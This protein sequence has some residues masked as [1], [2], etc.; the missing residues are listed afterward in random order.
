MQHELERLAIEFKA[1]SDITSRPP[2]AAMTK[3]TPRSNK[4][5]FLSSCI[6]GDSFLPESLSLLI[7]LPPEIW[8]TVDVY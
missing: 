4:S 1:S 8:P 3:R 2:V 5:S 7:E 6:Y